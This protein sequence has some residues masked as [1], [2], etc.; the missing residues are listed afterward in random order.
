MSTTRRLV[1][2]S[3]ALLVVGMLALAACA[4]STDESGASP[5][6]DVADAEP[7]GDT[8]L[9][10]PVFRYPPAPDAPAADVTDAPDVRDAL[11]DLDA[12]L[13]V[14]EIDEAALT[15]LV[16]RGDA[17]HA[18]YVADLMRFFGPG[19]PGNELVDAFAALTGTSLAD[20]PDSERSVWLSATN[21][22]I[23]W[24]TPGHPDYR[25]DKAKLFLL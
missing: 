18:W 22:L 3:T 10:G 24:D 14:G 11:A 9:R 15:D 23:A 25:A 12:Q 21:H 5:N 4:T 7:A 2:R 19:E 20:D 13:R 1:L 16:E 8:T 17:R 6:T